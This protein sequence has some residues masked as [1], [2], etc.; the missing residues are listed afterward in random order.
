MSIIARQFINLYY[1]PGINLLVGDEKVYSI[2]NDGSDF[3]GKPYHNLRAFCNAF[4]VKV[5]ESGYWYVN[6]GAWELDQ[7]MAAIEI[8][9]ARNE[10][11]S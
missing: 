8:G 9:D 6:F 5:D 10:D 2:A 4:P 7:I 11:E 1:E 3:Y